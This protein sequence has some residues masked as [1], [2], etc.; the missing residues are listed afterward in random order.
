MQGTVSSKT[1]VTLEDPTLTFNGT[2]SDLFT[3]LYLQIGSSTMSWSATATGTAQFS[4]IATING[5][6]PVKLYA[7]LKDTATATDVKFDDLRLSS[8]SKA[9]YVSNQNTVSSAVGSIS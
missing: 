7:T 3:T 8:F 9:E 4:G 1:Q 2:G 6:T 5:S